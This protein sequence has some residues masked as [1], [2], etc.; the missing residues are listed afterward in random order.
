MRA[1]VRKSASSSWLT[2]RFPRCLPLLPAGNSWPE[3]RMLSISPDGKKVA[4]AAGSTI[5]L[6]DTAS[7]KELPLIEGHWR[8]PTAVVLSPDGKTAVT[9]GGDRVVRRWDAYTGKSLGAF[10]APA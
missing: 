7:G 8:A 6:W 5:R 4:S 10:A 3:A 9:W 1:Q 2:A